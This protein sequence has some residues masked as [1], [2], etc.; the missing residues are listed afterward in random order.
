MN[1]REKQITPSQH[2]LVSVLRT[3]EKSQRDIPQEKVKI[4]LDSC[5]VEVTVNFWKTLCSP[6]NSYH[7]TQ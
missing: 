2:Q 1:L 5:I 3:Q 4:S 7:Y 6:D